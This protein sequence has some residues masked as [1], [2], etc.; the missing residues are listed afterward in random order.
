LIFNLGIVG[1]GGNLPQHVEVAAK[2][3]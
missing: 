3:H 1:G 2:K